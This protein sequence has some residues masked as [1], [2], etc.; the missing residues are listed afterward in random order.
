[1]VINPPQYAHNTLEAFRMKAAAV[2]GNATVPSG[3]VSGGKIASPGTPG[4]PSGAPAPSSSSPTE[5]TGTG[6][7][8]VVNGILGMMAFMCLLV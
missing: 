1:M 3:G 4:T 7:S 2:T 5:S 8:L 6:T